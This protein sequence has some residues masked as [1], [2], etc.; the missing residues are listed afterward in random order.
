MKRRSYIGERFGRL[1]VVDDGVIV[2]RRRRLMRV[3]C[4]CGIE[5]RIDLTSLTGGRTLSCGC[6]R[7]ERARQANG[8]HGES[9]TPQYK[10]WKAIVQRC[11]NPRA[12]RWA[13]YGGRGITIC[14]EWRNSYAA[15]LRDVGRRPSPNHTLDRYPDNDG[16]YEPGNVR[17]A[18]YLEQNRNR[19]HQSN[20]PEAAA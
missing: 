19:R 16:N 13:D 10:C 20:R 12:K 18:T 17:W 1:V 9:H 7:N 3:R 4:D 15:F 11:T 14:A 6:L 8:T 2:R 5:K